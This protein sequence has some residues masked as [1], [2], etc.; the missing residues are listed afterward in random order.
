M[1]FVMRIWQP[2]PTEGS[3]QSFWLKLKFSIVARREQLRGLEANYSYTRIYMRAKLARSLANSVLQG[4][5][6]DPNIIARIYGLCA[7]EGSRM[8]HVRA[9]PQKIQ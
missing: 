1:P 4:E 6:R 3:M 2:A 7:D 9:T 5:E 8:R